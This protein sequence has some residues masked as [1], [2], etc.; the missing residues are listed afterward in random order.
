MKPL[1]TVVIPVYNVERYL[2]RCI[3]SVLAQEWKDYEIL[4]VDDGST[5]NSPQICDDYVKAY[6]FISVIHKENGG[7]S[8]TR[9][10]GISHARGKFVYC[11]DSDDWIEPNT[12]RDLAEMIESDKFDIISFNR[13]FVK[14]V[15]D[16]IEPLPKE[17]QDLSGKDAFIEMLS[18]HYITG[19][20]NDKIYR[21]TLFLDN[22]IYFPKGHYYEDLAINYKL[23]LAAKRVFATNQKYYHY[24]I[25]NPDSITK[26]F[27]EH[28][29]KDMITY[30][31][32]IY[33]SNGVRSQLNDTELAI[34][35]SYFV[36]G[37]T[38]S[39]ASLYK[40]KLYKI[41]PSL[42]LDVKEELKA[43]RL[44]ISQAIH[45]P[46]RNKYILYRLGLLKA[47]FEL[48]NVLKK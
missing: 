43:N 46:N 32:K 27:N 3:E 33:Y 23:F 17:T 35:K 26:S 22:D 44:T 34:S 19:F 11:P 42:T 40:S 29:M 16:I 41:C 8:D 4:L 21:R 15:G 37:M 13:E 30:Y 2:K 12:F 25:D 6:D 18:H 7:I 45:I 9:N 38:H 5:D 10:T 1:L 20:V 14:G 28:K 48:Q 24:L 47:A 31:K 39:L 36:D